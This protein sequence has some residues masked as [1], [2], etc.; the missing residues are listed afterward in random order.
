MN[1]KMSVSNVAGTA[2]GLAGLFF[3]AGAAGQASTD[4]RAYS[5]ELLA[6]AA[7]RSSLL[8]AG[9]AGYDDQYFI[10]SADGNFR[11][12]VNG[13]AQFRYR[14]NIQDDSAP[15]SVVS[16]FEFARARLNFNGYA[17]RPELKYRIEGSFG[18][19][20]LLVP[21]GTP[22]SFNL[23]NAYIE[24]DYSDSLSIRAGQFRAPFLRERLVEPYALQTIERS[25]S[26]LPFDLGFVEGI[27]VDYSGADNW[28]ASVAFSDGGGSAGT[29]FNS[30]PIAGGG[31]PLTQTRLAEFALTGRFDYAVSG[32]LDQFDSYSSGPAGGDSGLLVGGAAHIQFGD[33][34][35][36]GPGQDAF[37]F[38]VDGTYQSS[39]G[40]NVAGAFYFR[41]LENALADTT[42]VGF[43]V[44]GG[45]FLTD[46]IEAYGRFDTVVADVA[47]DFTTITGGANF[48]PL[49]GT[50][51]LRVT[52]EVQV[53]ADGTTGAIVGPNSLYGISA[54]GNDSSVGLGAQFQLTF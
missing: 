30:G 28:R 42:D 20:N 8:Q 15:D 2:F 22:G 54:S 39:G 1:R 27:Q 6:D 47:G 37:L 48:F 24:Y 33:D 35:S 7:E 34:G 53:F 5:A 11:L 49:E 41:T 31:N 14:L 52:G 3:G 4:S 16:G 12:G 51:N 46:N 10:Q 32:T 29:A 43:L 19:E 36:G 21:G 18:T 13:F 9:T 38:T 40:W 26:S 44:Q 17:G 23:T 25:A 45:Y 50:R